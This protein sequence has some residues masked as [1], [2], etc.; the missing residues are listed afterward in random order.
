MTTGLA[1]GDW[2]E[3]KRKCCMWRFDPCDFRTN[4]AAGF[5]GAGKMPALPARFSIGDFGLDE[6][7]SVVT[8]RHRS[9][10][11]GRIN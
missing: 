1:S 7:G 11:V 6:S 10:L 4:E 8:T 3:W 5:A 2:V 9:R